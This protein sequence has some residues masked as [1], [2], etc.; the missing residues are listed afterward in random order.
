MPPQTAAASRYASS[1]QFSQSSKS[2]SRAPYAKPLEKVPS[3]QWAVTDTS[4]QYPEGYTFGLALAR[5]GWRL[6]G[7]AWVGNF[8]VIF[9]GFITDLSTQVTYVVLA[10]EP[11]R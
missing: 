5:L 3:S 4:Q 8:M 11:R 9:Y 7:L 6:T 2:G 10:F 1:M